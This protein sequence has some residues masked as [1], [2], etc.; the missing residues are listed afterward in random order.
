MYTLFSP[1][2]WWQTRQISIIQVPSS[3]FSRGYTQG[4]L[5]ARTPLPCLLFSV[6]LNCQRLLC[7]LTQKDQI[8]ND[9]WRINKSKSPANEKR[10]PHSCEL[11]EWPSVRGERGQTPISGRQWQEQEMNPCCSWDLRVTVTWY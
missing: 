3:G 4:Y 2:Y 8:R 1:S 7:H 9:C 11:R 5:P 10:K 6:I